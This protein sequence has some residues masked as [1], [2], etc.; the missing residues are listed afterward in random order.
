MTTFTGSYNGNTSKFAQPP[1]P[2]VMPWWGNS[3]LANQFAAAVGN[4]FGIVNSTAFGPFFAYSV[5]GGVFVEVFVV[6]AGFVQSG[7]SFSPAS[8][9]VW[10]QAT[11]VSPADSVPGPLPLFGAAA[12][13]GFS[14][15]LRKRI[16]GSSN[17]VSSTY[18]L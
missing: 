16:K 13:F 9:S 17:A 12:A 18:S 15:K 10:A 7:S 1:A 3:S 6:P 11:P 5:S 14:R 8:T 2:G 4:G